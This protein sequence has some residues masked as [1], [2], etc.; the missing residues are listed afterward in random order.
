MSAGY[1]F[2][3]STNVDAHGNVDTVQFIN[4]KSQLSITINLL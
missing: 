4:G 3:G 2:A 1:K